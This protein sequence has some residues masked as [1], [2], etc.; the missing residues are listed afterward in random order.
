[1]PVGFYQS[2]R[3]VLQRVR[4]RE[5]AA[6]YR[7]NVSPTEDLS[8]RIQAFARAYPDMQPGVMLSLAQAGM[9]PTDPAVQAIADASFEKKRKEGAFDSIGGFLSHAKK[10]AAPLGAVG[11]GLDTALG[12]VD[13]SLLPGVKGAV[14]TG[15]VV[16]ESP[17]QELQTFIRA[18][19]W[20]GVRVQ[21]QAGADT[22][23][24]RLGNLANPTK[25]DDWGREFADAYGDAGTSS[26]RE[27]L[28]NLAAGKDVD[29]GTGFL[30]GGN[31]D[32][33]QGPLGIEETVRRRANRLT[34]KIGDAQ[35]GG[36]G[37]QSI[38]PGRVVAARVV[39]PGSQQYDMLSG[40]LDA[41][42]A[43]F[44][45]PAAAAGAVARTARVGA[46]VGRAGRAF[47]AGD[48]GFAAGWE[49]LRTNP[50]FYK[51][52]DRSLQGR[53]AEGVHDLIDGLTGRITGARNTVQ[54][55]LVDQWLTKGGRDVVAKLAEADY[56]TIRL[57]T[58]GKLGEK[59]NVRLADAGTEQEVM[60]ILR[61]ALGTQLRE[62][63]EFLGFKVKQGNGEAIL[64]GRFR[65]GGEMPG[66]FADPNDLDQTVDQMDRWLRNA[67]VTPELRNASL[68]K[69][70]RTPS[71]QEMIA[72]LDS[73]MGDVADELAEKVRPRGAGSTKGRAR[74]LT[75]MYNQTVETTRAYFV[76]EIAENR[77]AA[78]VVVNGEPLELQ[79]PFLFTEYLNSVIPL[80]DARAVRR[81][82]ST[83]GRM[84]DNPIF[85]RT[86][87]A[88]DSLMGGWK[89]LT[90]LR[91]AYTVR[92]IGEEQVRMAASG[93][94][95][96]F[97]HPISFIAALAG[98]GD[99]TRRFLSGARRQVDVLGDDFDEAGEFTNA[100][101]KGWSG[102]VDDTV[103]DRHYTTFAPGDEGYQRAWAQGIAELHHDP[104]ARRVAE[105]RGNLTDVKAWFW[106]EQGRKFRKPMVESHPELATQ[107]GA[108]RYIDTLWEGVQYRTGSD[109][110]LMDAI[111]SGRIG[112]GRIGKLN[113]AGRWNL[114]D[115][116]L[117]HLDDVVGPEAVKGLRIAKAGGVG[118]AGEV[119][120][121]ATG[122]MFSH[123]NTKPTNY[124]SRSPTFRERYWERL[125]EMLPYMDD[126]TRGQVIARAEGVVP[127]DQL[128]R[129]RKAAPTAGDA[130]LTKLDDA[131]T[132]AKAH[133]LDETK[134]LL[135]DLTDRGQFFDTFRLLF[136]FGEAWREVLTRWAKIG[137]ENPRVIRRGQQIMNGARGSGF[138]HKDVNGEE[139]FTYP[140]SR[141]ISNA[142]IGMPV[143]L[144]GRVAGLSLMTEVLPGV[145][146]VVQIPAAA[147]LP[148]TPDW[149][150]AREFISPYGEQ[151][152]SSGILES[153]L[154][155]YARNI[156]QFF[157]A[158]DERL[159]ANTVGATMDHLASTGEYD[160][161]DPDEVRRLKDES[162]ELA[163]NV[164]LLRGIVQFGAPAAPMPEFLVE[165][166]DGDL[167]V[168]RV[169]LQDFYKMQEEDYDGAVGE[170]LD[171]YGKDL[172]L[173]TQGKSFSIAPKLPVTKDA[174]EWERANGDL[175]SKYDK[176]WGFFA[177][178]GDSEDFDY[179]AY[180]R[181]FERG[182]RV[183]LTPEQRLALAQARVGR[184]IFSVAE[185][186]L[187]DDPTTEEREWLA[188]VRER[189][190]EEYPG[191]GQMVPGLPARASTDQVVDQLR[192]AIMDPKLAGSEQAEAARIYLQ[193]RD[194]ALAYAN[195][196]GVKTLE[197]QAAEPAR[198]WLA[199]VAQTVN[200]RYPSFAEMFD[201]VFSREVEVA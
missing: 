198:V 172:F 168:A 8:T 170:F 97:A 11:R 58:G 119:W 155:G 2:D 40:L 102:W 103:Y 131:D 81:A 108:D 44:G 22:F 185:G 197:A 46:R 79:S 74:K 201:V 140:F 194:R 48:R 115:E 19:G 52:T 72:T 71:R 89:R 139:V 180:V 80:P 179:Q 99:A 84:V 150:F 157:E 68:E 126:T 153:F 189:I 166:K 21:E 95:S 112:S 43:W 98:N 75:Q 128:R 158:G 193:A 174:A 33:T 181:Q 49:A 57:A 94:D 105:G 100:L 164:Y 145:G 191:F 28:S 106:S 183:S 26:L 134:K 54:P 62:A 67:K 70:A 142:L 195:E 148:D 65:L 69:I 162:T 137:T 9:D 144:N 3:A 92:V 125:E 53:A 121:N 136:P 107:A 152:Y 23:L 42:V 188:A 109:P 7:A 178:T 182:D 163:R 116:L 32:P 117:A 146:P 20:A 93:L 127:K 186:K 110:V 143:D 76:D 147:I 200:A 30:P 56:T 199:R 10:V 78:G 176:V 47:R 60:D 83:L 149:D 177:P 73:V 37:N 154:P 111:A 4:N 114:S 156:R 101:N 187:S 34:L 175:V 63:P 51:V 35:F 85:E 17:L 13:E 77:K 61:P 5:T 151:D 96:S 59:L 160:L 14:R 18:G 91:G 36:P 41:G 130:S 82:T 50:G 1:M 190:R 192:R 113:D 138:F 38:T 173:L 129:M 64:R 196:I 165:D 66:H 122:W 90:L 55:D 159:F 25:W 27:S 45:D 15:F 6:A 29:V 132:I 133:A 169:V 124:L 39:E 87:G 86:T 12:G 24:E 171:R 120:D 31:T 123:L 118:G 104:V 88:L 184:H 16:L 141:Q 167:D 135:Y 161:T